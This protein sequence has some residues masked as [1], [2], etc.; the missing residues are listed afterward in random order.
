[1]IA[2]FCAGRLNGRQK[3]QPLFWGVYGFLCCGIGL[4]INY[5]LH[6]KY[7]F[8]SFENMRLDDLYKNFFVNL[9]QNISGLAE[10]FGY[11]P[12]APLLSAR[13]VFGVLALF[14]AFGII[15]SAFKLSRSRTSIQK[16]FVSLFF[17]CSAAFNMFVFLLTGGV[18]TR[19]FIPFMIF[20]ASILG[21][22][23]EQTKQSRI[24]R[25]ALA[26]SVFLFLFGQSFLNFQYLENENA[27]SVRNGYIDY[28][29]KNKLTYGFATFWN[30][31][32]STELSNGAV[33]I[34]GLEPDLERDKK[35]FKIKGWLNPVKFFNPLYHK[36]ESFLL[37]T[38]DEWDQARKFGRPFAQKQPDYED[39]AFIILRYPSAEII[40]KEV[41]D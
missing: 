14:F 25:T 33:E 10:F 35:N 32:V 13:G 29:V 19:Y 22:L 24:Y 28:L 18:I 39:G 27:N 17:I 21:F 8:S 11:T 9:G 7:R 5:L 15:C 34:A 16:Q 41:L 36:G 2:C 31:N 26:A 20:Y 23:L 12:G 37:L 1:V 38:Q 3:K 30:A 40:H 6:I 4:L